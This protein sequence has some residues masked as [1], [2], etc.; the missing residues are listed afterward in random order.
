LS[1]V[2]DRRDRMRVA[3]ASPFTLKHGATRP[4][5]RTRR[6]ARLLADRGH[7]VTVLSAGWWDGDHDEFERDGVTY[8]RVTAGPAP[9]RYAARLPVVLARLR[10]DV[11][12]AVNSPASTAVAAGVA[13]TVLRRPVVVDWFDDRP[14]DSP[15]GARL[16]AR[17]GDAVLV[18]SETVG[19]RVREWGGSADAVR[20]V[21]EPIDPDLIADAGVD[22]RFD[23]VYARRLDPHANVET[24][25][26]ALAELRGRDRDP[27]LGRDRDLGRDQGE[28]G[29]GECGRAKGDWQA[30]VIGDG[31]ERAR[32][33]RAAADLRIADR[34]TFTGRLSR[35][36][37][38]GIYR[39]AGGFVQTATREPFATELLWALACGCVGV[40]EYR[41]GSAAHE[42]LEGN[43]R[44]HGV[45]SP[46]EVA[47]ALPAAGSGARGDRRAVAD[48]F[49]GYREAAVLDSYLDCYRGLVG[50]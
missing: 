10:P 15:A 22:D 32:M 3:F 19:T 27:D 42:L 5:A 47:E 34:V 33:E 16:A 12:Q 40:V 50:E 31:P 44:C 17:A 9:L 18:P 4:R 30:A 46:E 24:F 45:T 37:R 20:V 43:P 6:T 13:G 39:G 11:I 1:G 2:A 48:G 14:D 36:E 7:E 23:Y 49:D 21:P 25:L 29:R 41:A 28:G 38:V 8:R 35:R 26:L